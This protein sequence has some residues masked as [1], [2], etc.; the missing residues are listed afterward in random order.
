MMWLA[1][2]ILD[3]IRIKNI[4]VFDNYEEHDRWPFYFL[5]RPREIPASSFN[6]LLW[7]GSIKYLKH[8]KILIFQT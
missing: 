7:A 5:I 1:Q 2:N 3:I 6:L 8:A 4:V